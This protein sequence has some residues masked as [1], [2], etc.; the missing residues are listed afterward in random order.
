[1]PLRVF[2]AI[3]AMS[4]GGC[5]IWESNEHPDYQSTRADFVC[6]PYGNCISGH[7]VLL[8]PFETDQPQASAAHALCAQEIDRGHEEIW[9]KESVT[10]GLEIGACMRQLGFRL[11]Q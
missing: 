3:L 10:R 11:Q 2:I 1:M 6:H 9:W 8:D 4:I 7:W 5:G